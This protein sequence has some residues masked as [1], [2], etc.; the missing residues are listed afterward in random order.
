[1]YGGG[2]AGNQVQQRQRHRRRRIGEFHS[3]LCSSDRPAR[4]I[5]LTACSGFIRM[6]AVSLAQPVSS[7]QSLEVEWAVLQGRHTHLRGLTDGKGVEE[8]MVT[9]CDAA[10]ACPPLPH[11]HSRQAPSGPTFPL[12]GAS[13]L[14]S[15]HRVLP[16]AP[17][18]KRDYRGHDHFG[19]GLCEALG[20]TT[21]CL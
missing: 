6:V 12:P 8:Q 10:A 1:M 16:A 18:H 9:P 20:R 14:F 21:G 5:R 15:Q 4:Q 19:T 11:C 17:L 13:A 2:R 7:A 3:S